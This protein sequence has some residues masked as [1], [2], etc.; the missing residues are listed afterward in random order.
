MIP[1]TAGAIALVMDIIVTAIPL[2]CPLTS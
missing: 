2:A 1:A